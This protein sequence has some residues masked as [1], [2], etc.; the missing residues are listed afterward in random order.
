MRYS[1]KTP[2]GCVLVEQ[3]VAEV[4][5]LLSARHLAELERAAHLRGLTTAQLVRHLV[6]VFLTRRDE[7]LR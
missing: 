1:R 5:L 3:E 4:H 6:S 7:K 2:E